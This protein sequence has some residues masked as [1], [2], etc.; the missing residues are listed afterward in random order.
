MVG[1][2]E[3][4]RS[5]QGHPPC[6]SSGR[7]LLLSPRVARRFRLEPSFARWPPWLWLHASLFVQPLLAQL[8]VCKGAGQRRLPLQGGA[9]DPEGGGRR[10]RRAYQRR[11]SAWGGRKWACLLPSPW[12]A[13]RT[14]VRKP[15]LGSRKRRPLAFARRVWRWRRLRG[16]RPILARHGWLRMVAPRSTCSKRSP[17]RRSRSRRRR[18]RRRSRRR[19]RRR[20]RRRSRCRS[21]RPSRRRRAK[22]SWRALIASACRWPVSA[23]AS[24]PVYLALIRMVA[25]LGLARAGA[26]LVAGQ[27]DGGQALGEGPTWESS[28]AQSKEKGS[29]L[30]WLRVQGFL[31]M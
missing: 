13:L 5:P 10:A 3:S 4:R 21:H 15:G 23:P 24:A 31:H 22:A 20:G 19:G 29:T 2:Q 25:S 9:R 14:A 26:R 27:R 12:W 6:L 7:L 11:R 1:L 30:T 28:L 17:R 16:C 18:R 8:C